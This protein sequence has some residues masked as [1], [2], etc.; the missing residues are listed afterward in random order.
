MIEDQKQFVGA[1]FDNDTAVLLFCFGLL[2][3]PVLVVFSHFANGRKSPAWWDTICEYVNPF[4]MVSWGALALGVLG[5]YSLRSSGAAEGYAVCAF[6]VGGAAGF[7]AASF[8][9]RRL[10]RRANAT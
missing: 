5:A 2:A 10:K 4:H 1:G 6:F 3:P 7:A 9:E 8:V